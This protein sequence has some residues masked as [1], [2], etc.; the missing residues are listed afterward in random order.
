MVSVPPPGGAAVAASDPPAPPPPL[1]VK[2]ALSAKVVALPPASTKI[3]FTS[4]SLKNG[5]WMVKAAVTPLVAYCSRFDVLE[6]VMGPPR[7]IEGSEL[8]SR[9]GGGGHQCSHYND[10]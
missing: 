5:K 6:T 9:V 3:A 7:R 8:Q 2:S 10:S 4:V 1:T